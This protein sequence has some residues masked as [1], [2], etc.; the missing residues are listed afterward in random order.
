[1]PE[2]DGDL[3]T[4]VVFGLILPRLNDGLREAGSC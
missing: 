2:L 3:L 4:T 1:M